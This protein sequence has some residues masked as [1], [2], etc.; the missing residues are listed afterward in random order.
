MVSADARDILLQLNDIEQRCH[1]FA[2]GLPQEEVK[3]FWEGVLFNV[4]GVGA[5]APL[6]EVKEIL[7]FPAELTK[8]PGTKD[9]VLGMANI[10]GNLLPIFDLQLFLGSTPV[11]IGRRSRVLVID[12][13]G[14]FAG[15]LIGDVQ[16]MRHFADEQ[17][18]GVKGLPDMLAPFVEKAYELDGV[19]RPVFSMKKLAQSTGFRVASL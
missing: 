2:A 7:N 19:V 3:Q 1:Q 6:D 5:I 10:R 14:M 9:W 4:A 8:V 13:E 15:L 11:P 18:A 16:G 17:L 12:H